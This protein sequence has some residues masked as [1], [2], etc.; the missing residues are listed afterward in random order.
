M[1]YQ[2]TS[3]NEPPTEDL[4]DQALHQNDPIDSIKAQENHEGNQKTS[5]FLRVGPTWAEVRQE[6]QHGS[7]MVVVVFFMISSFLG[8]CFWRGVYEFAG[9]SGTPFWPR[10]ITDLVLL[11]LVV[12]YKVL[13]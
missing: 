6:W 5:P 12:G 8:T 9:L 2:R 1:A 10:Y 4:G 11:G 13:L 7:K 3:R